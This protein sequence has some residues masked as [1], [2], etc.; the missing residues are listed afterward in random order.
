M[1]E[2][3][4]FKIYNTTW[5]PHILEEEHTLGRHVY[6]ERV[7]GWYLAGPKIT[8]PSDQITLMVLPN[9][10]RLLV[11]MMFL[12]FFFSNWAHFC[13]M[14]WSIFGGIF[15]KPIKIK[16]LLQMLLPK[17]SD[18]ALFLGNVISGFYSLHCRE[19]NKYM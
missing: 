4:H 12:T 8:E 14:K 11:E 2:K 7:Q 18:F 13:N 17:S 9:Y 19:E 15:F 6:F 3:V 5:I 1:C 16:T 10:M